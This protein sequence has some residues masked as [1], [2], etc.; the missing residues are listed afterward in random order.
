MK[1]EQLLKTAQLIVEECMKQ[2]EFLIKYS[3]DIERE[4]EGLVNLK[5]L[6][7]FRDAICMVYI[8]NQNKGILESVKLDTI[9]MFLDKGFFNETM[10]DM[11][12]YTTY[13]KYNLVD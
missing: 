5:K 8:A 9:F 3:D 10:L 4:S 12:V 7:N 2:I 11:F 6:D 1:T 13:I